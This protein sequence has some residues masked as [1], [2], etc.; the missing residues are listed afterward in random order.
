MDVHV[1]DVRK[2]AGLL[3]DARLAE[4]IADWLIDNGNVTKPEEVDEAPIS[5]EIRLALFGDGYSD[6]VA[7]ELNSTIGELTRPM[8]SVYYVL[9][10]R[11]LVLCTART[12]RSFDGVVVSKNSRF[13][14]DDPDIATSFRLWPA[15]IRHERATER[16]AM[17]MAED[18]AR[19]PAL[20][21]KT[22]AM[23]AHMRGIVD[24][25]LPAPQQNGSGS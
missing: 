25:Q 6:W 4:R 3:S 9:D 7:E 8:G 13:V 22:P 21:T 10:D 2:K 20:A 1:Y 11:G 15:F 24:R 5:D 14:T 18:T 17:M 16:L 19:I 23:I 12:R